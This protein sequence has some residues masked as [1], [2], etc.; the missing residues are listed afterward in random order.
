MIK[1]GR[2]QA[3]DY[4]DPTGKILD[5]LEAEYLNPE[6]STIIQYS[7]PLS[8]VVLFNRFRDIRVFTPFSL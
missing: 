1:K 5:D 4:T 2:V 7:H 3:R 8:T 6:N